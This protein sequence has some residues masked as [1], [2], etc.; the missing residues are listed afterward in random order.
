MQLFWDQS[1]LAKEKTNIHS[2]HKTRQ[3]CKKLFDSFLSYRG[4]F[5]VVRTW[6]KALL[7]NIWLVYYVT[8]SKHHLLP[9]WLASGWKTTSTAK[10]P[11]QLSKTGSCPSTRS[12]FSGSALQPSPWQSQPPACGQTDGGRGLLSS[13]KSHRAQPDERNCTLIPSPRKRCR[14]PRVAFEAGAQFPAMGQAQP[15]TPMETTDLQPWEM[16]CWVWRATGKGR[17][18]VRRFRLPQGSG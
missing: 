11:R 7:N 10:A 12:S 4:T 3:S 14:P 15:V 1:D 18:G 9:W 13:L 16:W 2:T 5:R 6:K 8:W 17:G